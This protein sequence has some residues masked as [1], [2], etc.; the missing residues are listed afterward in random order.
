LL[1][2]VPS[3]GDRN[4]QAVSEVEPS[5]DAL[6][7]HECD[8]TS[9]PLSL[10]KVL[11]HQSQPPSRDVDTKRRKKTGSGVDSL[12]TF[13]VASRATVTL[14]STKRIA[15]SERLQRTLSRPRRFEIALNHQKRACASLKSTKI[16]VLSKS[17]ELRHRSDRDL[18]TDVG[19]LIG[20]HR[21]LTAKLVAYLGEN[22]TAAASPLR[23][24]F[25]DV[26]VLHERAPNGR[27]RSFP[28]HP[29]GAP[30]TSISRDFCAMRAKT[31]FG[32]RAAPSPAESE[33]IPEDRATAAADARRETCVTRSVTAA[34]RREVFNR[35]GLQCTF[36]SATGRRCEA[37]AFLELDHADP[38]ALGGSSDASN[39]RV[40]CRAHNQLWAEEVYGREHVERARSSDRR[41]N[42]EE[43][44]DHFCWQKWMDDPAS[45]PSPQLSSTLEKV[46]AALRTMGFTSAEA[47]R[48]VAE[49]EDELDD[50]ATIAEALRKA[51][52][53]A[54][55]AA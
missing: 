40:R 13:Q 21:E 34:T 42:D 53:V 6:T 12:D 19:A 39:L 45:E 23:R 49:T 51:L 50:S 8:P 1:A 41:R 18:L 2:K 11:A 16:S 10:A 7:T 5:A 22:R 48:A 25:V 33:N 38:R 20:S 54:T 30:G 4:A 15:G 28:T 55:R 47:R 37:R 17:M 14:C 24:F 46:R 27:R 35:D 43:S 44:A 31:A 36:V 3:H 32:S 9:A 29:R 26:R 52:L